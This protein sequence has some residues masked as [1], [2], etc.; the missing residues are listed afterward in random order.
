[1]KNS[2]GLNFHIYS[3]IYRIIFVC[4]HTREREFCSA[5]KEVWWAGQCSTKGG[6]VWKKI[7][8]TW[9]NENLIISTTTINS[10][11]SL[12]NGPKTFSFRTISRL[13]WHQP[14]G[15]NGKSLIIR[16][17]TNYPLWVA[18]SWEKLFRL[19]FVIFLDFHFIRNSLSLSP[20]CVVNC[21]DSSEVLTMW[22]WARE[23]KIYKIQPRGEHKIEFELFLDLHKVFFFVDLMN[24]ALLE[25]V[26]TRISLVREARV[27]WFEVEFPHSTVVILP[28]FD[29][30]LLP[31]FTAGSG[32]CINFKQFFLV[33]H[34][35]SLVF[36]HLRR[37]LSISGGNPTFK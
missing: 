1:M 7:E 33:E 26:N 23:K 24:A 14:A 36:V 13:T 27:D 34:I 32:V 15:W 19:C 11:C 29:W 9:T 30:K 5:K 37:P 12:E 8:R 4:Y 6:C 3:V 25:W 17:R 28:N 35:L 21:E 22:E 2:S 31:R 20:L 18:C 10:C 16:H